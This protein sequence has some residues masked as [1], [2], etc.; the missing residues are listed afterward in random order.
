L[1]FGIGLLQGTG[2]LVKN[3]LSGAFYSINKLTG[4]ISTGVSLLSMDDEF[5][6]RRR[7]FMLRPPKHIIDGL[8]QGCRSV[9]S[10]IA[11]GI[12]G[13]VMQP[14]R[15]TERG[16]TKIV[17]DNRFRRVSEGNRTWSSWAHRET[18]NGHPRCIGQDSREHLQYGLTFR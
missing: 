9:C 7:V 14:I 10:G 8:E 15:G 11:D 5:L 6:E 12:T 16:G 2:S 1:D 4:S 18:N 17:F 3:T 13:V